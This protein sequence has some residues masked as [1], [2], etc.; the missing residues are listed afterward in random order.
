MKFL[1]SKF[2]IICAAIALVLVLVPSVLAA[3]GRTDL[4]RSALVTVSKPFS[5]CGTQ[6]AEAFNGFTE[7]F[8]DYDRLKEENE[9]LRA[10]LE[11]LKSE[12]YDAQVVQNENDWL[13]QYLNFHNAHPDYVLTD[14]RIIARQS[15]NYSTVLTLD[16]GSVHGIK[17]D[18]AVIAPEGLFGYVSEVGLD[19][20]KVV[21]M[22]ETA[23]SVGAYTDRSG[24]TGVVEGDLELRGGGMCRMTY[25][26]ANA[27]IRV[28]DRVYTSG[29]GSIYPAGLLIGTVASI[30]ADEASRTLIAEITPAVDFAASDD[31]DRL[32]VICGYDGYTE[33]DASEGQ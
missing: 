12:P 7:I 24:A 13:K 29:E 25:I 20:C 31:I 26:E 28:G 6:V 15:G 14:A 17:T 1:K 4:L 19:W 8:T 22:I 9:A 11:S 30:Q 21:T 10:E 18:M 2:F 33:K 27:D 3:A 5:W 16:R 23:S 32:M